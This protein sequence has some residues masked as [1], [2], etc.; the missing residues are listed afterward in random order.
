MQRYV[1]MIYLIAWAPVLCIKNSEKREPKKSENRIQKINRKSRIRN[2]K[3]EIRNQKLEIEIEIE[4]LN[5]STTK[6]GLN[7]S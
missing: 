4:I 3:L 5:C 6:P 7:V 1:K 2:Q